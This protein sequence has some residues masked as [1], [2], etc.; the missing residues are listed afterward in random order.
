MD[1]KRASDHFIPTFHFTSR[2]WSLRMP[3]LFLLP[4]SPW[5][6]RRTPVGRPASIQRPRQRPTTRSLGPTTAEYD[7][8]ALGIFV[9]RPTKVV[10]LTGRTRKTT[11]VSLCHRLLRGRM[12]STRNLHPVPSPLVDQVGSLVAQSTQVRP[13]QEGA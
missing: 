3:V 2:S 1:A 11:S 9:S 12:C 8:L 4:L 6:Q 5:G 7:R 13:V 10:D